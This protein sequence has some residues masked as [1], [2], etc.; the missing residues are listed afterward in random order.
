MKQHALAKL[1]GNDFQA[2]NLR[3][4]L[5]GDHGSRGKLTGGI[6]L[7]KEFFARFPQP[8]E[9]GSAQ[10]GLEYAWLLNGYI[11]TLQLS[12]LRIGRLLTEV[13]AKN[14]YKELNHPS[15]E[16]FAQK[17]LHLGKTSLFKYL[18]VYDW[19]LQFHSEWLQPKPKG[20]IPDLSDV[21]DLIWIENELQRT[22]LTDA[23]RTALQA[24]EKK[25]L[26]GDLRQSDLAPF[27]RRKGDAA[28][29]LK[30]FTAKL[31]NL[32][33]RGGELKG[34]PP[35]ALARLDEAIDILNNAK[36]H[37]PKTRRK[38]ANSPAHSR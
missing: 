1:V 33:K 3:S 11:K 37:R 10:E 30:S 18:H 6:D 27:R 25:G 7:V 35:D 4:F 12:Y 22:N 2:F 14:L 38:F 21:D 13:K 19:V 5:K 9:P 31:R 8:A 29:T 24:L 16:D 32:R 36:A 34:I 23:V 28:D 26:A 17:R 15:M 20:F